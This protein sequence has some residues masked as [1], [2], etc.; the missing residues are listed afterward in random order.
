MTP[1]F[2]ALMLS[3]VPVRDPHIYV[4]PNGSPYGSGKADSPL[5]LTTA[6]SYWN[7]AQP[8]DT[9]WLR[10]GTYRGKFVSEVSGTPERPIT[11]RS[12]PGEWAK[13]DSGFSTDRNPIVWVTGG[14]TIFRDLEITSS[15]P[16][17]DTWMSGP[18]PN[19]IRRGDGVYISAP[20][21]KLVNLVIHDAAGGVGAWSDAPDSEIYGC[22]IYYNGWQ[23]PDR[24]HGHGIYSQN[25]FGARRIRDNIIFGQFEK[26]IQIYGSEVAHLRNHWVEGNII[27]DN[28]MLARSGEL[29]ENLTVY[30]GGGPEGC[31][32]RDNLF[33]GRDFGGKLLVGGGGAKDLVFE[34]NYVPHLTRIRY[35]QSARVTGN[36]F[37]R[38][39]TLLECYLD[40]ESS[41]ADYFWDAN[42]YYD[43]ELRYSPFGVY[44]SDR[45]T[46]H[47]TG[48]GFDGWQL[49]TGFDTSSQYV[50]GRPT[51]QR[52]VL[53]P[54]AYDS[55]RAYLAVYNWDH[56]SV[57]SVELGSFLANGQY[58]EIY[59]AQNYFGPPVLT[60]VFDGSAV[61]LPMV[62]S[63]VAQPVGRWIPMHRSSEFGVFLIR[64]APQRAV[65]AALNAAPSVSTIADQLTSANTSTAA[66]LFT[67]VDPETSADELTI[68]ANSSN[69]AVVPD[70]NIRIDGNG[71]D[72]TITILPGIDAVGTTTITV[73]VS[74][75]QESV[76]RNFLV[77]VQPPN[78]NPVLSWIP[79]QIISAGASEHMIWFMVGDPDHRAEELT[80]SIRSSN[81]AHLTDGDMVVEGSDSQR[82]LVIRPV[83]DRQG[84]TRIEL[85]VSDG[86]ASS[87]MSFLVTTMDRSS[88][89]GE[90]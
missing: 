68:T 48:V 71:S 17:R 67:V 25:R 58:Y 21:T 11:V 63:P 79:D 34:N 80:V 28:G 60:G 29:S 7:G 45:G 26:G 46:T 89:P 84:T 41:L 33:Y 4:S 13:I 78:K 55:H 2:F 66:I 85:T 82:K 6:L 73:S 90:Q 36:T 19:D 74:D 50:K 81:P 24:A 42:L 22:I 70:S 47:G 75:G 53:K 32:I 27:F 87:V 69:A 39:S 3:V 14:W 35:W 51:G 43:Q 76:T 59:D 86:M 77:M 12:Y 62:G 38:D 10:G 44:Y 56:L 16:V 9:L 15:D 1:L 37:L 5:D 64:A 23:A 20:G 88:A 40:P 57:V 65:P 18:H 52:V 30:G 8:G 61:P 54:N 72:R 83:P 49:L 31:V